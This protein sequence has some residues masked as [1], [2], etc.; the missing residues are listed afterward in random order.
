MLKKIV[1]ISFAIIFCL[2]CSQKTEVNSLKNS[3]QIAKN[4]VHAVSFG[5][6]SFCAQQETNEKK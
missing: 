3:K 1:I 2:A 4:V 5:L 6:E